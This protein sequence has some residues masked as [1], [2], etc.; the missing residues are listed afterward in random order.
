MAA[1]TANT[2]C[3]GLRDN[4]LLEPKIPPLKTGLDDENG[5]LGYMLTG[6]KSRCDTFCM[7]RDPTV[8]ALAPLL[9]WVSSQVQT[10]LNLIRPFDHIWRNSL[11]IAHCRYLSSAGSC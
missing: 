3:A 4:E 8:E 7:Q 11:S 1:M 9:C 2:L 5:K 10:S 6:S